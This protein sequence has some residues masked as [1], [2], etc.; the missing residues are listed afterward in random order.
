MKDK[1]TKQQ[2]PKT[3]SHQL[4]SALSS[5]Q[6]IAP[7]SSVLQKDLF[8]PSSSSIQ[9]QSL[10]NSIQLKHF[11]PISVLRT[12]KPT[13]QTSSFLVKHLQ[14]YES[15]Q[16][17]QYRSVQEQLVSQSLQPNRPTAQDQSFGLANQQQAINLLKFKQLQNNG[18]F[19]ATQFDNRIP[20]QSFALSNQNQS[21]DNLKHI[22]A[23]TPTATIQ[24][25]GVDRYLQTINP[26][27]QIDSV[28]SRKE[29]NSHQLNH[30]KTNITNRQEP[31]LSNFPN[32]LSIYPTY[33][34]HG[35][36]S[37]FKHQQ[38]SLNSQRE[39]VPS[40]NTV[41]NAIS[42]KNPAS[43]FDLKLTYQGKNTASL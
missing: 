28:Y 41:F 42:S 18:L 40:G 14:A 30:C 2:S 43:S 27:E 37:Y 21:R 24:S 19:Q 8:S 38:R 34:N 9:Q 25:S 15:T 29:Y 39:I 33:A 17:R 12:N 5:K 22:L 23:T 13:A 1:T 36:L 32:S 7:F 16:I 31:L 20:I 4:Q 6:T 35:H 10:S 26:Q 11:Q 3:F